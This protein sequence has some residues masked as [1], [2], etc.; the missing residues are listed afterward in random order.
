MRARYSEVVPPRWA[1]TMMNLGSRRADAVR[2]PTATDRRRPSRL[3]DVWAPFGGA[4]SSSGFLRISGQERA[5]ISSD[6]GQAAPQPAQTAAALEVAGVA[7]RDLDE[8]EG[9]NCGLGR[10]GR[11]RTGPAARLRVPH[12]QWQGGRGLESCGA[13]LLDPEVNGVESDWNVVVESL[14]VPDLDA[15]RRGRPCSTGPSR[16]AMSR[17]SSV[18]ASP[19]ARISSSARSSSGIVGL[20]QGRDR[21]VGAGSR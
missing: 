19:H 8:V 20:R 1:P 7:C 4:E 10:S 11:R 3:D 5:S 16:R 6:P 9:Q 14:P 12:E 21:S 18:V 13:E 2:S 15:S 17:R